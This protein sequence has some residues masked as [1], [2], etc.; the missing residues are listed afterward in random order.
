MGGGCE[1]GHEAAQLKEHEGRPAEWGDQGE[2]GGGRG[3]SLGGQGEVSGRSAGGRREIGVHW[4]RE[5]DAPLCSTTSYSVPSAAW[6]GPGSEVAWGGVS[7]C[8][9]TISLDR[10][11][12]S[13]LH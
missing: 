8:V 1:L 6:R 4:A 10:G 5:R 2:V 7:D 9:R 3:W 13:S 11:E 12:P